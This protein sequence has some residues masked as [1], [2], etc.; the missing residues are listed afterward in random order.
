MKYAGQT[1]GRLLCVLLEI[2]LEQREL[3]VGRNVDA[4]IAVLMSE[5]VA[6]FVGI[7]ILTG[8]IDKLVTCQYRN[9]VVRN[10]KNVM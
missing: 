6:Y 1:W 8:I 9:V 7:V 5:I 10:N 2:E 3:Q 4:T